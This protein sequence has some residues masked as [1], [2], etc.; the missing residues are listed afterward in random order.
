MRNYGINI[1]YFLWFFLN[2]LSMYFPAILT[3]A[4]VRLFNILLSKI[5]CKFAATVIKELCLVRDTLNNT[6]TG[7]WNKQKHMTHYCHQH[8]YVS[9]VYYNE[10]LGNYSPKVCHVSMNTVDLYYI[11]VVLDYICNYHNSLTYYHVFTIY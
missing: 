7:L 6:R 2:G 10:D 9:Q 5:F 1:T 4:N 8:S 11:S 3:S